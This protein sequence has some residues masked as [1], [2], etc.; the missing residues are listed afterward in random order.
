MAACTDR[1]AQTTKQN[2]SSDFFIP[3][4]RKSQRI[5]ES[6]ALARRSASIQECYCVL[7]LRAVRYLF[8]VDRIERCRIYRS[9]HCNLE[10]TVRRVYTHINTKF[11]VQIWMG[12]GGRLRISCR[13]RKHHDRAD[14]SQYSMA[15]LFVFFFY[16]H[17][18]F[19]FFRLAESQQ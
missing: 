16:T 13:Y 2:R 6:T 15:A 7:L 4:A 14:I 12:V 10:C 5:A 3:I 1:N 17:N 9:N 18:F 11:A 19:I 8:E